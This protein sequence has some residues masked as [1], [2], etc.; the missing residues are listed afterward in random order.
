MLYG[1]ILQPFQRTPVFLMLAPQNQHFAQYHPANEVCFFYLH[2]GRG[3]ARVD[4]PRWVAE[5]EEK[6]TAVHAL[7]VDQCRILGDYPYIIA[8]ADELAVVGHQDHQN[9][10]FLIEATMQKH[11]ISSSLTAKQ[12]SKGLARSGKT[13]FE[14]P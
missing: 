7:L 5:D 3:I 14:G 9:L 10:D 12:G 13:R 4:I 1:R 8:R 11:G 2:S 6:V